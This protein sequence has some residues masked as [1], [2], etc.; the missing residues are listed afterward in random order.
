MTYTIKKL[1]IA[2]IGDEDLV[3]GMRSA[4]ANRYHLI[5]GDHDIGEEVRKA[6]TSLITQPDVGIVV[7]QEGYMTYVEEVILQ[8]KR[9]GETIPEIVE[10]PSKYGTEYRDIAEYYRV[11]IRH[12]I[13][14]DVAI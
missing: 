5:K 13:G 12:F 8:A 4:G 9:R 6:I 2:I 1:N 7:I 3:N 14:F 10:V 11:F